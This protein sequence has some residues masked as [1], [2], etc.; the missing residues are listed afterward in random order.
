MYSSCSFMRCLTPTPPG[1][2]TTPEPGLAVVLS[3]ELRCG[4]RWWGRMWERPPCFG[5]FRLEPN[6]SSE[7]E[8]YSGG[9]RLQR[10]LLDTVKVMEGQ[11]GRLINVTELYSITTFV[12]HEV[13]KWAYEHERPCYWGSPQPI[14][15]WSYKIKLL[16]KSRLEICILRQQIMEE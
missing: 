2:V 14:V 12:I 4:T 8:P 10:L 16:C 13:N 3:L 11:Y 9:R 5:E 7:V 6:S 1:P 15:L